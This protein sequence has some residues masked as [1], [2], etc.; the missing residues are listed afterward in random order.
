MQLCGKC[1]IQE[2]A[3]LIE[4][5]TEEQIRNADNAYSLYQRL[6]KEGSYSI[7]TPAKKENPVYY[8]LRKELECETPDSRQLKLIKNFSEVLKQKMSER[9]ITSEELALQIGTHLDIIKESEKGFLKDMATAKKL[10][11]FFGISFL[12][13]IKIPLFLKKRPEKGNLNLGNGVE[14]DFKSKDLTVA[15]LKAKT[16]EVIEREHN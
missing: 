3:T 11:Q 10:E 13:E 16:D 8:N 14:I 9:Q 4:K 2:Q 6:A 7:Q 5:P 12:E 15:E 1:V